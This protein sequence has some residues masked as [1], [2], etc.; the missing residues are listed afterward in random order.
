MSEREIITSRDNAK[1]KFARSVRDG[2]EDGQIFIEG[3]R[4][5]R[6]AV[7]SHTS[8]RSAFV[9][10]SF[11]NEPAEILDTTRIE[12]I[13]VAEKAFA[14]IA[15][16]ENSQGIVLIADRPQSSLDNLGRSGPVV[17]IHQVN[18]PSNL[19][20]LVR[21]AEAAGASG[22]ITTNGSADAFS[23]KALRAS[24]G[25][26][27]RLPI[28]ERVDLSEAIEWARSHGLVTTAADIS[29]AANYTDVDW[30]V[31]RLLVFGSEA[32]GLGERELELIDENILI[33]MENE[34]ESLNLAVSA[35]I[36]LFEAKRQRDA[37]FT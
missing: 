36:V 10:T 2:R 25:S 1:L 11:S 37:R 8:I 6:E 4:L 22:L 31:P 21:T 27:F 28:V 35:G 18:N 16:T 3:V 17:L 19:G 14:S 9:S 33:P 30:T 5:V 13:K 12:V 29:G 26:A 32:H 34:V 20:A 7:R 24:M 15:D 23:P